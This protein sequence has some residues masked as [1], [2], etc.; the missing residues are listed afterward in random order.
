MT[1]SLYNQKEFLKPLC[2]SNGKSQED[3]VKEVLEKIKE[4]KKVIFIHGVCGTGKSA[5]ALNIAKELGKASVVV[6][7]KNLQAQYKRDYEGEK[8]L[9]KKNGEKLKISIIT[10][11]KNH[12]CKFLE[13]NKNAIPKIKKEIDSKLYDIFSKKR[14]EIEELIEKDLSA[15]NEKIPC[16]I[17]L[18]ERNWAKIREYIKQNKKVNL[19]DFESIRD[20]KRMSIAPVCPYWSPVLP[21]RYELKNFDNLKKRSYE[22][23]E[24]TTFVQY[25]RKAGCAFYEQFDSYIESDVIVFNAL[26]YKLETALLRK[27]KTEV[28]IID[29]CDEFLDSFS[30]ERTINLDRLQNSL[31]QVIS[32][33]EGDQELIEE[34]FEIIKHFKQD[35]RINNLIQNQGISPLKATG[36]YDIL[37]IFLKESW[38]NALDEESYLFDVLETAKMFSEFM[39]ESYITVSK[40]EKNLIIKIVTINLAKKL[41]EIVN[42]NKVIIMMS[43]TLHSD[44]VLKEIFG[45]KDFEKIEAETTEQGKVEIMTTNLEMDCKYSNF[46][47]KKFTRKDYLKAL[48][49]SIEKAP[50]PTLV[51]INAYSDLP[52]K[53]EIKEYDL[54]NILEREEI[55]RLQNEDKE[56]RLTK[57]FKEGKREILFST[58]D[59]RGVDFPG[60]QCKSI[61]FTKY[62]NPNV[63]DPFWKI[64][65]NTKPTQYWEFYRDKA[66]RE[67]LQ[68]I[69]R[70]LR[71]K[72]DHIYLLSPDI[73]VLEM[74]KREFN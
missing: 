64:L 26:K 71:F 23:L 27:P 7:G 20:V 40:N 59:S 16:K 43:G 47:S 3:I 66:R 49:E 44:K 69:Y 18:K 45:L 34:I 53:E 63:Q 13:D 19:K 74:A 61:V 55:Q 54:K 35:E 68:K 11:R 4:G 60:D 42:K 73:R 39:E 36:I 22:G 62:P 33:E 21:E 52:T 2:F 51:H 5:I 32:E 9:L 1:W 14:D 37:K 46:S 28:E 67:F 10:G 17:E 50:R 56:G 38:L 58:R 41:K 72:E 24:G 31:I 6:P 12:A 70:G 65:M 29:E 48:D 57:E 30:N 25:K 8:Y 15:S